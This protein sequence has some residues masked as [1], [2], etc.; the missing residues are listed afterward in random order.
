MAN[1]LMLLAFT[2]G[3]LQQL[4]THNEDIMSQLQTYLAKAIGP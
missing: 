3:A 1:S 2:G 4:M